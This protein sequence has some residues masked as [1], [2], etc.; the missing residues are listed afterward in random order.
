M[1]NALDNL[2]G[3]GREPND[4]IDHNLVRGIIL[5]DIL[6]NQIENIVE[7]PVLRFDLNNIEDKY[8]KLLFRFNREDIPRLAQALGIPD[9]IRTRSRHSAAGV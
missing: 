8:V 7:N 9:Q 3:R 5:N 2:I 4:D 1:E 6:A